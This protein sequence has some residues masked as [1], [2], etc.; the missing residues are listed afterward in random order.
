MNEFVTKPVDARPLTSLLERTLINH[1]TL[2]LDQ[3]N[4]RVK[5][6]VATRVVTSLRQT[7]NQLIPRLEHH[8]S[9]EEW[10]EMGAI[11]HQLKVSAQIVGARSFVDICEKIEHTVNLNNRPGADQVRCL[12]ARA[13]RLSSA[14]AER[15]GKEAVTQTNDGVDL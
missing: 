6:A 2:Q 9:H 8:A 12:L 3:L 15:S 5:P 7:L 1:E 14:L 4:R 13:G 11:A 10:R